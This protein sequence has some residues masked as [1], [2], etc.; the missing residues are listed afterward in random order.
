[1][2]QITVAPNEQCRILSAWFYHG[3]SPNNDYFQVRP[4]FKEIRDGK[5]PKVLF[6][7]YVEMPE[8]QNIQTR[9]LGADSFPYKNV[10]ITDKV[11]ANSFFFLAPSVIIFDFI[12]FSLFGS[13]SFE[14]F[15]IKIVDCFQ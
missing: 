4:Y 12:C 5:R 11:K 1:M 9:M 14:V 3:H 2:T 7:E 13:H 15:T 10:T 6:E 8:Y